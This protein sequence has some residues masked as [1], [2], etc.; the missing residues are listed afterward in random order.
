MSAEIVPSGD[1]SL[2]LSRNLP[3]TPGWAEMSAS[4][5]EGIQQ[6][7]SMALR[8]MGTAFAGKLQT[9]IAC[10]RAERFLKNTPMS[11][12]DWARMNI[13]PGY[14]TI[15]RAAEKIGES[16]KYA[17]ED[18]LLFLA[19]HGFRAFPDMQTGRVI[20]LLPKLP[21]PKVKTDAARE[22]WIG[23]LEDAVRQGYSERRNRKL[24]TLD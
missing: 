14:R 10:A 6:I 8:G 13:G 2:E 17:T 20:T 3:Q 23:Q 9:E 18:D 5:K 7:T 4:E 15:Y 11:V 16:L 19:Q 1:G 24:R 21:A 12:Q 22:K